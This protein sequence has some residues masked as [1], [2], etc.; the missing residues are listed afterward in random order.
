MLSMLM[1]GD[2]QTSIYFGHDQIAAALAKL[3]WEEVDA[4]SHNAIFDMSILGWRFGFYPRRYLCTLSMARATTHWEIGSSSLAALSK[5][6]ELPAKGDAVVKALGKRL[7]NF[8][9][10]EL[11]H[12]AL[13]CIRDTL[14]C[15]A[16]YDLMVPAFTESELT[17]IDLVVRMHVQPQV[18]LNPHVL[19]EHLAQVQAE[20]EAVF[21]QVSTYDKSV[22][23]S[24]P[25]FQ[26]LL[27]QHNVEVPLKKSPSTG[28]MIPALSKN[29]RAFKE[30]CAD[31]SLPVFIQAL[32]AARVGAKS[33]LDESRAKR[34]LDL[35]MNQW[36]DGD[37]AWAPIPLKYSGARTHRLS[38][39]DQMNWQNIRRGSRIKDAVEAPPGM[40]IVHRDSSQ[41]EARMVAHLSGCRELLDAFSEGRDVYCEFANGIY[42]REITK[43][44]KMERFVG[45]TAILGLG[46]G[47]GP[48]KF[49]HMCF[50]GNGGIAVNLIL[51]EAAGIVNKY[52]TRYPQIKGLWGRGQVILDELIRLAGR[53]HYLV[54]FDQHI[55]AGLPV[56]LTA[57][58]VW[59]PSDLSLTYPDLRWDSNEQG[60][61]EMTYR[62]TYNGGRVRI[63]GAKFIENLSQALARIVVTDIAVRV[64]NDT[65]YHPCLSTHD[66]LDYVVPEKDASEWNNYLDREFSTV[67]LWAP[68]LPLSS[69]GGWGRTL[70]LAE[71]AANE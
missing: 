56:R 41:I 6:H 21:A 48:D 3:N 57:E 66:S 44:D 46:Y 24:Q 67:P 30:M 2:T 71:Q 68:G 47:C 64:Y 17:L 18:K 50:I 62:G 33:T 53:P 9:R 38:G 51:E 22:F 7:A 12:Y 70:A 31:A 63:Y 25:Q 20:K 19:A 65:G 15:K 27:E 59:L 60:K 52:R 16:L 37:T 40:R 55:L 10:D 49:R 58:R 28:E 32:L 11:H 29:D 35:S 23:S 39:D 5:H 13:Y 36:P 8:T 43:A 54:G 14:N 69:E 45:K 1:E 4:L 26:A 34:L 61:Q 42:N